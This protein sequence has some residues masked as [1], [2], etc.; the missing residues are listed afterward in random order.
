VFPV[1]NSGGLWFPTGAYIETGL[2]PGHGI[3]VEFNKVMGEN[4]LRSVRFEPSLAGRTEL[5]SEKTIVYIFNRDPDPETVFTLIVSGDTKDSEGLKIGE[6]Y[7]ISFVADI[8]FLE[9]LS[10]SAGEVFAP[11]NSGSGVI[12]GGSHPVAVDPA[13]GKFSFTI[14]FS[15]PFSREEKQ[16]AV[17]KISLSPFFPKNLPSTALRS[18]SWL[19]DDRLSMTWEGLKAGSAGEP[20]FYKLL[21]PGGKGGINS[22]EGIYLKEDKFLYL[23]AV[24]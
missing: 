4:V 1:L 21:I 12:N 5:L 20:H 22:G 10:F 15:L 2:G 11:A 7:R 14:R 24:N 6:D 17:L 9:I 16:N 19:S 18:V 8:P 3:A 23:E 13:E